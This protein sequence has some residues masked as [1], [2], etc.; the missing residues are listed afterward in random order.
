MFLLHLL[1]NTLHIQDCAQ[2][3]VYLKQFA[4]SIIKSVNM[5]LFKSL[6]LSIKITAVFA[7]FSFN[8]L[9]AQISGNNLVCIGD[10]EVYTT[11]LSGL[12]NWTVAP[13]GP[14]LIASGASATITWNTAANTY[15]LTADNGF[16]TET[17]QVDVFAIPTPEIEFEENLCNKNPEE[18]G[19]AG[20][21]HPCDTFCVNEIVNY[22]VTLDINNTYSWSI[23][24][25]TIIAGAGTNAVDVIWGVGVCGS[26][27]LVETNPAGCSGQAFAKG[28][29]AYPNGNISI[30]ANP[31]SACLNSPIFFDETH[32]GGPFIGSSWDF[33][34]GTII[35]NT[36]GISDYTY[37]YQNPGT[38]T[39]ILTG[40]TE[41]CSTADTIIVTIDSLAGP[42][43]FCITPVCEN[44]NGVQYCTSATGCSYT[45]IVNAPN[46][47]VAGQ[48]TNCVTVNWVAGPIGEISLI[49]EFCSPSVCSDTTTIQVPIMPNGSFNIVGPTVV[50]I[51]SIGNYLA[52]YVP[53]S[54]YT[55]T[56]IDAGGIVSIL[57]YNFP[58]YQQDI[59]FTVAGTYTLICHMENDI[60]E[61]SGDDTLTIEVKPDFHITGLQNVCEG[62][63]INFGTVSAVN[64]DWTTT[65]PTHGTQSGTSTSYTFNTAGTYI[66]TATAINATAVCNS[67]Q[68]FIVTVYPTPVT[69]VIAGPL[70]ICPDGVYTYSVSGYPINTNYNWTFTDNL[71]TTTS[72]NASSFNI[73]TATGFT[74]GIVTV[75]VSQNGC[76]ASSSINIA[77]PVTPSPILAVL[78]NVCPDDVVTYT[79]GLTYPGMSTATWTIN[80]PSAGTIISG[81]GTATVTIEWHSS[82]PNAA[83]SVSVMVEETV[84]LNITGTFSRNLTINPT[85]TITAS[86][87]DFCPGTSTTLN[88]LPI[89]YTY[90]WFDVSGSPIS[91][92]VTAEGD[93]YVIGED[94][95]GCTGIAYVS[96]EELPQPVANITSPDLVTCDISGVLTSPVNLYA[97]DNGYTFIWSPGGATVNP[98]VVTATGTYTVTVTDVN[99][100]TNTDTYVIDCFTDTATCVL[101]DCGCVNDPATV[102]QVNGICSD[103]TFT[104]N[105][106]CGGTPDWS[107]GDGTF[108]VGAT[109]NHTYLQAGYYI[110]CYNNGDV[111][112]CPPD[113]A[114]TSIAVPVAANFDVEMV[115]NTL[116]LFNNASYLPPY[117]ITNY[118]WDFGDGNTSSSPNPAP[119][120]YLVGG[121]YN[122]V[123]TV[124]SNT[125]CTATYSV[126][127]TTA[128]PDFTATILSSACNGPVDFFA[129]VITGPI[130]DWNWDFGDGQGSNQQNPQHIYNTP[131]TYSVS[132]TGTSSS[133]C[134]YT[135]NSSIEIIAP[136]APFNLIYTTPAC[137][138]TLIEAPLGYTS[139]QW[140]NNGIAIVGA[141]SD[142]YVATQTGNYTVQVL[143]N[144]N[145]LFTSNVANVII[146]PQ[147]NAFITVEP[148]PICYGDAFTLYSNVNGNFAYQWTIGG[149]VYNY[150]PNLNLASTTFGVG[151][152]FVELIVTDILTGCADTVDAIFD[153]RNGVIASILV[154]DPSG[155][156]DGDSIML[157]ASPAGLSYDWSTG[158]TINPIYVHTSGNYTVTVTD[159]NGCSGTA[160]ANAIVNELPDLSML[161]IGCDSSC[162]NPYPEIIH[163]PPG[164]L[165]YNWEINNTTVS[166]AQ[167]LIITPALMP[168]YG[169]PYTV[170][171]TATSIFGCVDST[172]FEFTP[173]DC[174]DSLGCFDVVDTIICNADGTFTLELIITNNGP[175]TSTYLWIHDI[176]TPFIFNPTFVIPL[177]LTTGQVSAPIAINVS[178]P[179]GA[180]LPADICY[181]LSLYSTDS[182]CHDTML[183]CIPTPDCSPCGNVFASMDT[184]TDDCCKTIDITNNY[185]ASYFSG[186]QFVPVSPGTT[187]ASAQLGMP[188]LGSWNGMGSATSMTFTPNTGFI[189]MGTTAGLVDLCLN[190]TALSPP[191][192]MVL[193]NWLVSVAGVDTIACTDTL[194]F[195]CDAP[196]INPCG[197]INGEITCAGDGTYIYDYYFFNNSSHDV[198]MLVFTNANPY[199]NVIPN[200]I[201]L[202]APVAPLTGYSGSV[203]ID[204]GA[205]PAG[206]V[207][208]FDLTLADSTGWCCHDMD[209]IC[210]I[211]PACDSCA[212]GNWDSFG[213]D[214]DVPGAF[215]YSISANCG[216]VFTALPVGTNINTI[217]GGYTCIGDPVVCNGDITWSLVDPTGVVTSGTGYPA[218]S[219]T[220]AGNYVLTFTGNC[221][222]TN[223]GT[224]QITFSAI[225]TCTCGFWGP[226]T[227]KK[228]NKNLKNQ[229][230][231][232]GYSWATNTPI[233]IN[234]V[235]N[236]SVA[237][238]CS[239]SYSWT[240]T[241]NGIYYT[242]GTSMPVNFVPTLPGTYEVTIIPFCNGIEC[243][244]CVFAFKVK[245]VIPRQGEL[246][247]ADDFNMRIAPNPANNNVHVEIND[248]VDS[249]GDI[250]I[251]NEL[252]VVVLQSA[253]RFE[254]QNVISF[255][256]EM[257]PAGCYIVKYLG[258]NQSDIQQLIIVK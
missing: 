137:G 197:S 108:D 254:L 226:I 4:D 95:N 238:V 30:T 102:N 141:T 11:G 41:C 201:F 212:C 69:P 115:C 111:G 2:S 58:P 184:T 130:V 179:I 34:D 6:L 205:Y 215:D 62:T 208:C 162:I 129:N 31:M 118:L 149:N 170:S 7:L 86:G 56:L 76:T 202:P 241:R 74:N 239:L 3:F 17:F 152:H 106:T 192:Q 98:L 38:Y 112:C 246:N 177:T 63:T 92:I 233:I 229:L 120:T 53:G 80:P 49:A 214:V 36:T 42:D 51:N 213:M 46:T 232:T 231:G 218:F 25:G 26:L 207:Y 161:P 125:G 181:K 245:N 257:L 135:I 228:G 97:E 146:N 15:V 113:P 252:G 210:L 89:G 154:G 93:Y 35:N 66:V 251:I 236:C 190:L 24:G 247:V 57:P 191:V 40:F 151:S 50:C 235:Y 234:G 122:V 83:Q 250:Y 178:Y 227:I 163:G 219:L 32:I 48:G 59:Y 119:Y 222:G 256:V 220:I 44:T 127:V 16:A 186:V 23:F 96:V 116:T 138:S 82:I 143:D 217:A 255:N 172:S 182:C 75:S 244:P 65:D 90:N 99:G 224:C 195:H 101:P 180:I 194:F 43:I 136:P 45:W 134:T 160:S 142:N 166:T 187:I 165:S 175:A 140:F 73:T 70:E 169:L 203:I 223:C 5:K 156:C 204:P 230:C 20:G 29:A 206:T 173:L 21:D 126:L 155:V 242:S 27:V 104:A 39:V 164:M 174:A 114:C 77:I 87:A 9:N 10:V 167:D 18:P 54:Q 68:T 72:G 94:G 110:V 84:C 157:K 216:D 132:V 199:L 159:G 128:G 28:I 60:L 123:L 188:Y 253:I 71:G 211:L 67:P 209:S 168:V 100:C 248:A 91:N 19:G 79:A 103:F 249:K 237:D 88:A 176:T 78:Q 200:P 145:C 240:A 121:T 33:G 8:T 198:T 85:P 13:T 171:L 124:T 109:V 14:T 37:T 153:I 221:N 131:S 189:P 133:G 158:E 47:I 144:N 107:F 185:D 147:P 22:S 139:Y 150:G 258:E 105:S 55:W 64:C 148:N 243:E 196:F 1:V 61:C 193:V 52:P 183:Y 81:Q 12:I 117:S 225:E